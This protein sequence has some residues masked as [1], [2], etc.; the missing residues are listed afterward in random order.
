MAGKVNI[1][2]FPKPV[3]LDI[4]FLDVEET[5]ELTE[6]DVAQALDLKRRYSVDPEMIEDLRLM[7]MQPEDEHLFI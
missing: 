2:H 6:A 5:E 4:Q 1:H 3:L 7:G